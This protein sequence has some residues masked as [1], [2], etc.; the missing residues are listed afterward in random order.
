MTSFPPPRAPFAYPPRNPFR[1]DPDETE[2]RRLYR[3]L[4]NA[5]ARMVMALARRI[6]LKGGQA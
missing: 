1:L 2:G 5:E 4:A 3:A 6:R